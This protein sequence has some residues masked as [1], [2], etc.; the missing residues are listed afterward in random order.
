MGNIDFIGEFIRKHLYQK[1][2]P[3]SKNNN[4]NN[5]PKIYLIY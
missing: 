4:G 5:F 2:N 3:V 1:L